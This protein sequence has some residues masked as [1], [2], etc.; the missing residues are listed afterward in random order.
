MVSM[1]KVQAGLAKYI[2]QELVP[3]LTGWDKVIVGGGSGLLVSKLP[4]IISQYASGNL[5]AAMGIYDAESGM[6]DVD[7]IYKAVTEQIGTEKLPLNVPLVGI[8]IKV[9]KPEI[10]LLYKFITEE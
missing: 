10:D 4:E 6:V 5:V 8:T 9:G 3:A 2:D 7:A 1:D